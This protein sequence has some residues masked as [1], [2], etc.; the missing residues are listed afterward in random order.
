MKINLRGLNATLM[1]LRALGSLVLLSFS[2]FVSLYLSLPPSGSHSLSSLS[3][4]YLLYA[5]LSQFPTVLLLSIAYKLG[6]TVQHETECL[7]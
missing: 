5:S 4:L 7:F 1:L 2:V 6:K 3:H